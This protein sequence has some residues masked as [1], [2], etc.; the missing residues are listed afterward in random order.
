MEADGAT[1]G[2]FA[3]GSFVGFE[4]RVC[5]G[6]VVVVVV[7]VGSVIPAARKGSIKVD[8]GGSNIGGGN[9]S[10][11]GDDKNDDGDDKDE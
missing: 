2:G 1:F 7:V 5:V 6:V 3:I 8:T 4:V 9:D 10:N 11:G